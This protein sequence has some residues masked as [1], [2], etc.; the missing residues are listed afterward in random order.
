M[1][2]NN[3]FD[4]SNPFAVPEN[5]FQDFQAKME[6]MTRPVI[7]PWYRHVRSWAAIAA[8]VAGILIGSH[9]MFS[10]ILSTRTTTTA[11]LTEEENYVL[12]QVDEP[13]L[14]DYLASMEQSEPTNNQPQSTK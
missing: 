6:Q 14:V 2:I 13:A 7:I 1:D 8:A 12:S 10:P 9:F 5:Y 11:P 3:Y 4:K